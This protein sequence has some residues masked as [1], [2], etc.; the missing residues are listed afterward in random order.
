MKKHGEENQGTFVHV[1]RG[2]PPLIE[3]RVEHSQVDDTEGKIDDWL[4]VELKYRGEADSPELWM[5]QWDHFATYLAGH[6]KDYLE[7]FCPDP[8]GVYQVFLEALPAEIREKGYFEN[9]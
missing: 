4:Y 9:R 7:E 8:E 5:I 3:V 1:T 2:D 6:L